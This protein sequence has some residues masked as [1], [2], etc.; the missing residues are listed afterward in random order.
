[1]DLNLADNIFDSFKKYQ[2]MLIDSYDNMV[3]LYKFKLVDARQSVMEV[4]KDLRKHIEE[5]LKDTRKTVI[6]LPPMPGKEKNESNM[7]VLKRFTKN[8]KR[9]KVSLFST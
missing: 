6:S 5:I 7:G 1:M 9:W 4:Q 2:K 8:F 3:E